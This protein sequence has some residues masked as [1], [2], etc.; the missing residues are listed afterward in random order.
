VRAEALWGGLSNWRDGPAKQGIVEFVVRVYGEEDAS[1]R[2][3]VVER[4]AACDE[5]SVK[6]VLAA[7]ILAAYDGVACAYAPMA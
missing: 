6:V 2:V 5:T 4:P 3:P 1:E 7:G